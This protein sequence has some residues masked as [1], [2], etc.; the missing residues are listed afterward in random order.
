MIINA[1]VRRVVK[2][3]LVAWITVEGLLS[4]VPCTCTLRGPGLT[5]SPTP[6]HAPT[7]LS[8]TLKPNTNL[9]G[10]RGGGAAD[11][12]YHANIAANAYFEAKRISQLA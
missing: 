12:Q 5:V 11:K 1:N 7:C 3:V 2:R 8:F 9:L 4:C 10:G 6:P